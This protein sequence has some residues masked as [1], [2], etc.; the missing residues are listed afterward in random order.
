MCQAGSSPS[1]SS[2]SS[3]KTGAN[4]LKAVQMQA[5]GHQLFIGWEKFVDIINEKSKG[6]LVI[7]ILGGPEVMPTE[8]QG[9][10][11]RDGVVDMGALYGN[12]IRELIPILYLTGLSPLTVQEQ[13]DAGIFDMVQENANEANIYFLGPWR[14]FPKG[15]G[16]FF[17]YVNQKIKRPQELA[18]LNLTIATYSGMR[19]WVEA[20][21]MTVA[22]MPPADRYT[23]MERGVAQGAAN[24]V[25]GAASF[26]YWE[27]VPYWIDYGVENIN[28]FILLN[29]DKWN[30]LPTHLQKLLVDTRMEMEPELE[31]IT[32]KA[33]DDAKAQLRAGG[34]ESITFTAEDALWYQ[35]QNYEARW[36]ES[37]DKYPELTPKMKPILL[38]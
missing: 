35:N 13:R 3:T 27:V 33:K 32:M 36:A 34:M 22:L 16:H 26:S 20:L 31:A 14:L 10:A 11:L 12:W 38:P 37:L 18:D 8:E 2:R 28:H 5:T 4:S 24:S 29:L 23:A 7:E 30:S 17:M 15:G 25:E 9:P 21:G 19:P 1:T 6:E